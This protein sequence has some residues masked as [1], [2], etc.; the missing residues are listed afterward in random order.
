MITESVY[1][2]R[3]LYRAAMEVRK[4]ATQKV[5]R[6]ASLSVLERRLMIGAFAVR[7]LIESSKLP[8]SLSKDTIVCAEMRPLP[9]N[10]ERFRYAPPVDVFQAR[11]M[12]DFA[13]AVSTRIHLQ[14]MVNQ[15]IHSNLLIYLSPK[16]TEVGEMALL[17]TSDWEKNRRLLGLWLLD[18]AMVFERVA[19]TE[20]SAG[21]YSWSEKHKQ[22][23]LEVTESELDD[24]LVHWGFASAEEVARSI[25][26][27]Q[28]LRRPS[29][30]LENVLKKIDQDI[31]ALG[32]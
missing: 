30:S 1:W 21:V 25:Q 8:E 24:R 2:R 10:L 28:N 13:H 31:L 26:R 20:P 9:I 22:T 3:D 7:R 27:I 11:E 14:F 5:W 12:F 15:I 32:I 6:E 23:R 29:L 19:L 4:K 18:I 17:V 16:E